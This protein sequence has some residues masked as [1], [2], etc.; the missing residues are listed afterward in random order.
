MQDPKTSWRVKNIVRRIGQDFNYT[1]IAAIAK[2]LGVSAKTVLRELDAVERWL[3]ARGC[4]LSKKTG[5]GIRLIG[6]EAKRKHILELLSQTDGAE[7][8]IYTPQARQTILIGELIENQEPIKLY[9]L[10]SLLKVTEG[11]VSNDL[12]KLDAWFSGHNLTLV[13]KP[14][15]GVYVEGDERNIR[16]AMVDFIYKNVDQQ[17]LLQLIRSN[18]NGSEPEDSAVEIKIR[19]RLLHLMDQEVL[20]K[21]EASIR[22]AEQKFQDKLADSAYVGLIVHLAMTIQRLRRGQKIVIAPEILGELQKNPEYGLAADLAASMV[23]HFEVAI[24]EDEI[25]YIAMHLKGAKNRDDSVRPSGKWLERFQLTSLAREMIKIAERTTGYHLSQDKD[26][27]NGLL[28]HLGPAVSRLEMN[29]DI[30][31]PYLDN[32]QASYPDLLELGR[33]CV[34]VVE[35]KI[36]LAMPESEI[37]YIAMHLGAAIEKSK[38]RSKRVYRCAIA[39]AT[40][41]GT[42]RLLVTRIEKE[43]AQLEILDVISTLHIKADSLRERGIDFIISTVAIE[44]CG[45]PVVTVNPLLFEDDKLKLNGLLETLNQQSRLPPDSGGDPLPLKEKLVLLNR[46]NQAIMELTENFFVTEDPVSESV[47]EI[48]VRVG[49]T[50]EEHPEQ[51][52]RLV[53]DLLQRETLQDTF[54]TGYQLVLLHCRTV[55]V[56]QLHFGAVQVR[57]PI[58]ATNANGEPE[59]VK[60][61]IVMLAPEDCDQAALETMSHVSRMLIER[62]KFTNLLQEGT[63]EEAW[64]ELCGILEGF[65][66]FHSQRL[67]GA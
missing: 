30:R 26:L 15:L 8:P 4:G 21:L 66:K 58:V 5:V 50:L 7:N 28:N 32:M 13:R 39:C 46:Y 12:D 51:R 22:E 53:L 6:N 18:L 1:T 62:P 56:D 3:K 38:K 43:Y 65:Y 24:G 27:L 42:S 45:L 49:A 31:N 35:K 60:L 48:I 61:G 52:D 33:N 20:H 41:I 64:E 54:I 40:G 9:S 25:G 29:L 34:R 16:Q 59:A 23:N 36:G 67:L 10:A 11:T 57:K 63:C 44:N 47:D 19:Q 14:G 2:D 55:A 37:A 17:Q